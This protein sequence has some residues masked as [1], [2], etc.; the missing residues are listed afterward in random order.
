MAQYL[1]DEFS[2]GL[3]GANFKAVTIGSPGATF[4]SDNDKRILHVEHSEDGVVKL[5]SLAGFDT[6]GERL[7]IPINDNTRPED[8]GPYDEHAK[9][10]YVKSLEALFEATPEL[11]VFHKEKFN[12]SKV[13]NAFAG[14]SGDDVFKGDNG[15]I[16]EF[17]YGMEGDDTILGMGGNDTIFGNAGSDL[18]FGGRGKDFLFGGEGDDT[19][20]GGAGR[21][22]LDGAAGDDILFGK[23]GLGDLLLGGIGEDLLFGGNGKD[24]LSGGED[25]DT[26]QGDN[27][28]DTL[29]GDAG[30]DF[31]NGGR[32]NDLLTGGTGADVFVFAGRKYEGKDR[33]T[34]FEVGIDLLQIKG[35][36]L[37]DIIIRGTNLGEDTRVILAGGTKIILE[38]VVAG[39]LTSDAFDFV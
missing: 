29:S 2:N 34:D 31:I 10:L 24:S 13:T 20:N 28:R 21:D 9:E 33:I 36:D 26:L 17:L 4:S 14:T 1:M 22:T 19:L 6:A 8:D 23:G 12:P 27:G 7:V 25:N 18:V 3:G 5:G 11:A 16:R 30:D 37:A 38:G 39:D 15:N 32:H 35:G